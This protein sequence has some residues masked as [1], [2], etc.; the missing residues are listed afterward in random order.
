MRKKIIHYFIFFIPLYTI[1][2]CGSNDIAN[3][4]LLRQQEIE[5]KIRETNDNRPNVLSGNLQESTTDKLP[6][7]ES[8]CFEIKNIEFDD[9]DTSYLWAI[10]DANIKSDPILN[11]CIGLNGLYTIR[12]RVQ[13]NLIGNGFITSRVNI[14]PQDLTTGTLKLTL[15]KGNVSKISFNESDERAFWKNAFPFKEGETL[16]LRSIEQVAL[17]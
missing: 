15:I 1:S 17:G 2:L 14:K 9:G 7:G 4:Q 13:N 16:N 6:I 5:K 12:K 3:D 8:P 11:R 10:K